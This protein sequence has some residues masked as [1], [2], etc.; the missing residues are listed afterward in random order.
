MQK[1]RISTNIGKDQRVT[2]EIKQDYDLLEILSLKFSQQDVYTS[3]C[4]DYGVVCGRVTANDGFG[5]PNAK[6]S[7]FVPQLTIHSD[8][9]VISALYPYTSISEKDENNYR[10]NLLPARKQHGGHVPTGTF[11]DQTEILTREEYLEVYESYYTYTVKT[12]ESG[13]FMIW[14]VPLGQQTINVD[15]D[16]SDIGCFS[17]RPYDFIKKGVGIDQFDRYYNFKSGS[18]VDGLPQIVNFQKT[19]EV[20]PFWGNIDLCQIGITRTDF[21]LLDKGIKIEPISLILMSTITDDNG[22][23]IKRSGVIRRKSGYKCNLQTTEGR[24]EAVRYTGKKV[25]GS[26][27]VTLYPE[28]EY[29][30]PSESIDTDGT[31]MV[32]LPVNMEYVYT[33]EFGEQ[34]IT[35][36]INKGIPT[37]TVARFRFTLDGNNDKTGTAKY[38]VPQIREYNSTIYGQN[39]LGEYKEELLTTYQF[40]NV[41]EDYLNIIPP[42]GVTLSQMSTTYQNDKKSLMLGTNNEGIPEDVFYK[43]IF[44]KVY[45]VSSF[46]GS[47]YETSGIENFLGL[48]RKDAFLGIKEIRPSVEDDCAS[49]AN[50]FPTNFGFRNRIKFG[51]IVSEI[52][53][54]LQYIFTIAYIFI[55][56]TLAGT[57]WS[58]ARFLGPKDYTFADHPFFDFSVKLIK[59][60]YDLQES[61]QTVLPLTTYPDCEECTSDVDTVDP[62]NNT[63]FVIEEG[64]KKYDKFYNENLVYAYIWSNNN[65]YGTNT[66]PSNSGNINGNGFTRHSARIS[67]DYLGTINPYHLLG[68]P[69]YPSTPNLK[70]QL[71]SPGSGW[72]IMAAVV[73]ATGTN[74]NIDVSG[75]QYDVLNVFNTTTRRLPN[76]VDNEGGLLYYNKK[77]K[78]GLTEIRDGVITVVPVIDGPSKSIDVIKEWYKRKRVGVFFC[79]GVVNYSFID[80]WLNGI[81]Y[82]FKFDKRIRWDD[83]AALDLNQRGSKYPRELVFFNVLDKE[84]YYRA[85]PYNP[86][87]GFIGQQYSGYK[88]ILHPT[89]FYDVGV[90]DEFLYEIC[91]DPRLDVTC[92]VVRDINATSYQDPANIVEYAINYRLDTNN[93]NFDVGDF[94]TGT[95]MGTNVNV[96]DGDITQLMSINC[97]AGIE[98]FDLDSPHYFFYNGEI[99]DPEDSTLSDFF[100]D[101]SGNYGPTPIDLKFDNNGA[102]IRQCLNF[103]L[104]DYSQKVPFYLWNKLGEGFG[105]FDAN[106]QDDQ[107]WD[108]TSIASMKLQRLFSINSTTSTTTN[109]VMADGEEE[110]LLRPITKE[111]KG[112]VFDGDYADM[113]ERFE[114][115]MDF[116]PDPIVNPAINYVE[117]D[118]WLHVTSGTKKNPLAGDIYVVVNKTWVKETNQYVSGSKETFLFKTINNYTGTKQVL[119]TPFLFYFGLRPDKTSLDT[120]IK[121]YGPKGAF[122]ST[123]FCL[124]VITPIPTLTPTPTPTL[125]PTLTPT[126]TPTRSVFPIESGYYYYAMGDCNDLKYSGTERTIFGFGAPLVIPVCMSNAQITQWYSTAN[127]AQQTLY[128]DYDSPCGFGDGYVANI[129]ARS[130]TQIGIE[131]SIY[132]IGGKCLLAIEIDSEYATS[133]TVNLDGQTSV[134]TGQAACSSCDPPFTGFTATG[135]S[136]ITCDT[137]E[138]VV[139]YSIFGSLNIDRVYGIQLYSGGTVIGNARCMTL[140]YNL[141]PQYTF[142]DPTTDGITGYGIS[143]GGP[144]ILGQPMFQGYAD[145]ANC[146]LT[147]R[148]YMI[149]GDRCDTT[150]S[151]TIWSATL[152]T[153]VSGDTMTVSVGG[154]LVCFLVTQADQF[155]SAVY[156]DVGFAIVDTGCDCNGN[157]GGS[158]VN[159]TNVNT[160]ISSSYSLTSECQS[161]QSQYY[162]ETFIEGIEITFRGVNNTLVVPNEAVQYRTNGGVWVPLTVTTSTITLSVTLTYGD[163]SVCDGGGTYGDTLDIKVGT[164]TV[165]NYVAGQ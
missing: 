76:V 30:N 23:A 144:F 88:E 146:N 117:G 44:G 98:A 26:D 60:A 48:S 135:Y 113:L 96:F 17:L 55:V 32:V 46:Q 118:I 15:I 147:E 47:H 85:T 89:T 138:N 109:Y 38:L 95:G 31:A 130:S 4:A 69:Y 29:F 5:I 72:T 155:T 92:S 101:G 120:L 150:G 102:F 105:S 97:E 134:G 136:G 107:Q 124:D 121:Y 114:A 52:L 59:L 127:W 56:E 91:Q 63:T 149:T 78:S 99:M 103:R 8:D 94:F 51:L 116:K 143:D 112:Y 2:V 110:Y 153:V 93:G 159:V 41:F 40:S 58:I 140:K 10:Y 1:H 132:S 152:P 33:N 165:L 90:R 157:S 27:K 53:L 84:F 164:I 20:Y 54:F 139:V 119:S 9:P 14:G 70:E 21:D 122:P 79:G 24:I 42:E 126:P 45:T 22:D 80:N 16:L 61:G 62:S 128:I 108:K 86:T 43:F 3:L 11:P 37:T 7:I 148:K 28:L 34:E 81:L 158:N 77:T 25:F 154:T 163:R 156:N 129:I 131:N 64:C 73:G 57:L 141:G 87:S 13:D 82:F 106:W 67:Y 6:V 142:T 71:V 104:G 66:S 161:P 50:Y 39:D 49:K 12:N 151:V 74:I 83:E 35:N 100:T 160:S 133:W 65:S 162:S 123:D 125:T 111:H 36:D 75:T 137:G 145:C 18:D 19:V 115:I 68:K